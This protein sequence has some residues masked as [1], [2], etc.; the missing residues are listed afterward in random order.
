MNLICIIIVTF[1]VGNVNFMQKEQVKG[2]LI[3]VDNKS[4]MYLGDF[5]KEAKE[6][7]FIGDYSQIL[8]KASECV[9]Y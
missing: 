1:S 9:R 4:N 3:A 5:S 7:K 8:V 2:T 6:K